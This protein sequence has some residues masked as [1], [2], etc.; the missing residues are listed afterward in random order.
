MTYDDWKAEQRRQLAGS[1]PQEEY[2]SELSHRVSARL[3]V[4]WPPCTCANC[5]RQED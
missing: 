3:P 1:N 5:A 4:G 2:D